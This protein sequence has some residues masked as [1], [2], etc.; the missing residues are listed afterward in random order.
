M[1][2]QLTPQGLGKIIASIPVQYHRLA[3]RKHIAALQHFADAYQGLYCIGKDPNE[4]DLEWIRQNAFQVK[5]GQ[6]GGE[7][8]FKPDA[9]IRVNRD[10]VIECYDTDGKQTV[11]VIEKGTKF[12]CVFTEEKVTFETH[13]GLISLPRR[14][15]F[16]IAW[17]ENTPKDLL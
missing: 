16:F 2:N 5:P 17:L 4:V 13:N 7:P 8:K 12:D 15:V 1:K 10:Q 11:M 14:E 6:C 3:I 9:R